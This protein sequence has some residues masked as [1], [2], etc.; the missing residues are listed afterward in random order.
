MSLFEKFLDQ[1][2]IGAI[3]TMYRDNYFKDDDTLRVALNNIKKRTDHAELVGEELK[4]YNE[5]SQKVN[6]TGKIFSF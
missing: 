3:I 1:L 6:A 2:P 5:L 4:A